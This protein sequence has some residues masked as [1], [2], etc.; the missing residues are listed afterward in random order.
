M[1]VCNFAL[2]SRTLALFALGSCLLPSFSIAQDSFSKYENVISLTCFSDEGEV[3]KW[4]LI[5]STLYMDGLPL[6]VDNESVKKKSGEDVFLF[7]SGV[8]EIFVDFE[9]KRQ[10]ASTLGMQFDSSCY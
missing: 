7:K 6:Q 9:N 8:I 5:D 2:L 4:S 3:T 10:V 1:L